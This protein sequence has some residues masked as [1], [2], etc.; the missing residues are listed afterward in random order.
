VP[1]IDGLL[2]EIESSPEGS[3]IGA[4]FDFDGTL[5]DGYSAV[6]YFKDRI[7][8]GEV[9][10]RELV[11]TLVGAFNVEKRGQDVSELVNIALGALAGRRVTEIDELGQRLFRNKIAGK[12]YPDAR[13]LVDAHRKRGHTVVLASSATRF[14][15]EAAANDLGIEHILVTEADDEDGVLTGRIVGTVLWGE[16]KADAVRSFADA[17][18]IDLDESFAYSNG[19]EDV[20]FLETVGRPHA[21]NPD[22]ELTAVARERGW[23][24]SRLTRTHRR[25]PETVVRSA[26]AFAGLGAGV[27]AGAGL[28]LVNWDRETALDVAASVG[29]EL[30]LAAADVKLEVHGQE[31]LWAERPAV[32]A[33]NHQSQLDVLILSALLR[34]DFTAVAK[35]ELSR[36]PVFAPLGWLIDVAYVDRAN[37]A[38]ARAALEP[39]VQSLRNGRSLVIAPEGTRSATPRLLPFKKGAFHVAMQAGVPMVPIVIRNAG[40][41]MRPHSLLVAKGTVQVAVLPPVDTSSWTVKN[42]GK[43][44]EKVREMFL[45][46][47]ANW[48][49][50]D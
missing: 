50:D 22:E 4:F 35:K 34:S 38:Q 18:G 33:F 19:G 11:D 23:P 7:T 25:T 16:G 3:Q 40:E 32:F 45:S 48:P 44:V 41:I 20:P 14:Q 47:L 13:M 6:V 8:S 46:T 5:I 12:L 31:N 29:T 42:L 30:A 37:S 28:G 2:A 26:V 17:H 21:L 1:D 36:D 27:V 39:A 49:E 9:G 15:T 10:G 43:K 24:V